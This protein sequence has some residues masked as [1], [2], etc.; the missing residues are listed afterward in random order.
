MLKLLLA[1]C[2]CATVMGAGEPLDLATH[3]GRTLPPEAYRLIRKGGGRESFSWSWKDTTF[4]PTKGFQVEQTRWVYDERNGRL[5]DY[6]RNQLELETRKGAPNQLRLQVVYYAVN[7]VGPQLILEGT[8]LES[9][10]AKAHF[11]ESVIL[12]P[13]DSLS[14]LVDVFMRD[15]GAFLR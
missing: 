13:G 6:L 3:T 2:T 15:L 14:G 9:G 8:F 4:D 10:K 5:L 1:I 7:S 12:D 11:V